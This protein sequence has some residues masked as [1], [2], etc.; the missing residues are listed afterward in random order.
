MKNLSWLFFKG[1]YQ[2]FEHWEKLNNPNVSEDIKKDMARFFAQKNKIFESA[3][4]NDFQKITILD[5]SLSCFKLKTTYPGLLSGTGY[6]HGLG[7]VGEYKIG[8]YFDHISGLPIVP[9]SSVK[10]LIRSAFPIIVKDKNTGEYHLSRGSENKE[11]TKAKWII[12]LLNHLDD[13]DFLTNAIQPA[14][15]DIDAMCIYRLNRLILELFEGVKDVNENNAE[16][17]FHSIYQRNIFFDA[18]PVKSENNGNAILGNDSITPH[19]YPLKNPNPLLFLKVLPK[20]TYKFCFKLV[21]SEVEAKLTDENLLKLFQ[22][23]LLEFG[24][25]AKTNVGYGQFEIA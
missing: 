3:S 1:Y 9:G 13:A 10:G 7:V 24:I 23:I 20:V 12:S 14:E 8:F 15:Q 16:K 25:G 18:I 19:P 17:R 11:K 5:S 22:K 4:L 21:S 2:G 6:S